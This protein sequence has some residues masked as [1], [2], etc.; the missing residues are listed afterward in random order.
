MC[1]RDRPR[2]APATE[3]NVAVLLIFANGLELKVIPVR[4]N[5]DRAANKPP[6]A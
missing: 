1:I 5:Q 3:F 2:T 4:A 6:K